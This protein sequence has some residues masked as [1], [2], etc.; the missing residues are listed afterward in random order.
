MHNLLY[1][2]KGVVVSIS[3]VEAALIRNSVFQ[4]YLRHY[5]EPGG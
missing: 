4:Y 3:F 5:R 1:V 2:A